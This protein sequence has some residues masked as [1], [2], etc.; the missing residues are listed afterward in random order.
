[1][2]ICDS[3]SASTPNSHAH[4]IVNAH[5]FKMAALCLTKNQTQTRLTTSAWFVIRV[6]AGQ[7]EWH[8]K[9]GG[10]L[11]VKA[12]S[13]AVFSPGVELLA[14]G[15]G[16]AGLIGHFFEFHSHD[17]GKLLGTPMRLLLEQHTHKQTPFSQVFANQSLVARRFQGIDVDPSASQ[18]SDHHLE[19]MSFLPLLMRELR[20]SLVGPAP[21]EKQADGI[22]VRILNT[23]A[24]I[25]HTELQDLSVEDLATRCGC[26]RRHFTRL[27]VEHF[28]CSAVDL[29]TQIRLDR[30][31]EMLEHSEDKIVTIA[32][33]CGFYHMGQFAALF[34]KRFGATPKLWRDRRHLDLDKQTSE[35]P[36]RSQSG[37]APQNQ[38]PPIVPDAGHDFLSW[39]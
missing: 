37:S 29:K 6:Q 19:L 39:L 7:L 17:V 8:A 26:S 13:L 16:Q 5:D 4:F 31:A 25:R 21:A 32:M 2:L 38:M 22:K 11:I 36:A 12:G 18:P 28:G 1:M 23:L 20:N 30:A 3:G 34:R 15:V 33:E 27:V 10:K 14:K 24:Q 35:H 9:E